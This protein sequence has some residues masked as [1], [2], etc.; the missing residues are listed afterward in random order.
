M[1][2]IPAKVFESLSAVEL[3]KMLATPHCSGYRPTGEIY[4]ELAGS[5]EGK[6]RHFTV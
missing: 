6:R 3:L 1:N 4:E 5:L 2:Y